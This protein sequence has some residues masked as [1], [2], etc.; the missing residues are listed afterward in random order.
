MKKTDYS[1][2]SMTISSIKRATVF[3]YDFQLTKFYESNSE[4][5]YQ[6]IDLDLDSEE[7]IICSMVV[8][9]ENYSV[10]TT[11]RLI[12][13][14]SGIQG[15]ALLDGVTDKGYGLFKGYQD[16]E[17]T[18]GSIQLHDG[19]VFRY[20]IETGKASMIM[21]YG[22]RTMIRIGNMTE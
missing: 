4:F 22:V 5:H 1:K 2:H 20:F 19:T 9:N 12:T 11:R 14:E 15:V 6:G 7:L 3:P 17:V 10:L 8:D 16:N 21:I 13:R 18:F